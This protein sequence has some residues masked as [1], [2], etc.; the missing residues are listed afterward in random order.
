[1]FF[2]VDFI[3]AAQFGCRKYDAQG[4]MNGGASGTLPFGRHF[5]RPVTRRNL[6]LASLRSSDW[7]L[8]KLAVPEVFPDVMIAYGVIIR[9]GYYLKFQGSYIFMLLIMTR[10]RPTVPDRREIANSRKVD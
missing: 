10:Y 3:F 1:M 2:N 6:K 8:A 9:V 5:D 7:S 4:K